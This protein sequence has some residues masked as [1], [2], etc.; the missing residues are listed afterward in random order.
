MF[1]AARTTDM[2]ICVVTMGA[3]VPGIVSTTIN[4]LTGN[5]PQAKVT[6][7][8]PACLTPHVIQKGSMTVLVNNLP[9]A[10]ILDILNPPGTIATGWP[11]VLIGG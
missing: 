3:P 9:A 11:T 5:M 10:R 6:D 7:P 2:H 8:V 4:V 1:P